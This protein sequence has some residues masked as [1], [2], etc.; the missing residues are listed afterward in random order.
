M[1]ITLS[2]GPLRAAPPGLAEAQAKVQTGAQVQADLRVGIV[3]IGRNEGERLVRCLASLPPDL[4]RVYVD[5]G[6]TDGSPEAAL[7]AGAEVVRLD[8]SRPF[9]AARARN[10]GFRRL[11][12]VA[13]VD[14]VQFLDGDT[15]LQEGWLGA[16]TACLT[17]RPD[18][19]VVA[20]RRRERAPE[21]S[22]YNHLCDREWNTPVGEAG[23]VG[24][25]AL[26]R[27][28]ALR[29][30]G[31]FD[32]N[33]IAGEEPELCLRLR[34]AGGRVFRLDEE[35][36]QHDA[37]ITRF[38]AW[39]KRAERSGYAA[40]LGFLMH[41]NTGFRVRETLRPVFWGLVLPGTAVTAGLLLGWQVGLGV[42][43]LYPLQVARLAWRQ[44]GEPRAVR[45]AVFTVLT[46]IAE[47]IGVARC[48]AET[49][50]GTRR[51]VE[52]K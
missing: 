28:D 25:D 8:M 12:E 10:E 31:G 44:R 13:A 23:A 3:V 5:S 51:I 11:E 52:Y 7:A 26:Y 18:V 32:P 39:W 1:P 47:M 43:A 29:A 45:L 17:A 20:G 49:A 15:V 24:G 34:A 38:S 36:T 14:L 50:S 30:A 16:A 35:M 42:L 2:P 9:S 37:A 41:G 33:V 21:A 4:P 19:V 27:A 22:W 6:S 40:A 48:L 46:N